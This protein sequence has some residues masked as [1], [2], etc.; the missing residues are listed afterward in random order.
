MG[1]NDTVLDVISKTIENGQI[2]LIK[3]RRENGS[4]SDSPWETSY[5][6]NALID[7]NYHWDSGTFKTS[8]DW[9]LENKR[10]DQNGINWEGFT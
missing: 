5:C 10:E 7:S 8:I 9:L 6:I 4:W 1:R 2:F 3:S